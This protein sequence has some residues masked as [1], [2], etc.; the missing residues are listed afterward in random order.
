[1]RAAAEPNTP[2][3]A[4]TQRPHYHTGWQGLRQDEKDK[5]RW[6]SSLLDRPEHVHTPRLKISK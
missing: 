4:G 6:R 1:M 5:E 2:Q 3:Q